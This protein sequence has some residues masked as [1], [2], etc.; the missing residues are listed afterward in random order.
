M[1]GEALTPAAP[2]GRV[3]EAAAL[4]ARRAGGRKAIAPPMRTRE[5][6]AMVPATGPPP[7]VRA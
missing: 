5:A 2:R 4:T 6:G 1:V 7:V 3:E